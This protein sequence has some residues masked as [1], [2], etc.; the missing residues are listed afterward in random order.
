MCGRPVGSILLPGCIDQVTAKRSTSASG[1]YTPNEN[2]PNLLVLTGAHALKVP[3]TTT[4]S[5]RGSHNQIV[6]SI[7]KL[8]PMGFTR[9]EE[10]YSKSEERASLWM[11]S[12]RSFSQ[13]VRLNYHNLRF[14]GPSMFLSGA[15]QSPQLLELSG[16]GQELVLKSLGLQCHIDLPGVGENLRAFSCDSRHGKE[17]SSRHT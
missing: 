13:L 8:R 4:H 16:I 12:V 15:F 2:L 6:R 7:R 17:S 5:L 3:Y 1:Y 14:Y 10:S 11:L 9:R